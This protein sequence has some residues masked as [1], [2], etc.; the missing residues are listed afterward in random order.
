METHVLFLKKIINTK[1]KIISEKD[2][3]YDFKSVK[4]KIEIKN[5]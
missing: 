2:P 3:I 1:F 5:T 4:N